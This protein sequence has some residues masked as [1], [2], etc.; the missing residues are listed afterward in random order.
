MSNKERK[1]YKFINFLKRSSKYRDACI[2]DGTYHEDGHMTC[3]VVP[4]RYGVTDIPKFKH[5][6]NII[7]LNV[8]NSFQIDEERLNGYREYHVCDI[9]DTGEFCKEITLEDLGIQ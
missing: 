2:Y 6:C 5:F 3:I 9:Y 1:F 7:G 8:D 4:D